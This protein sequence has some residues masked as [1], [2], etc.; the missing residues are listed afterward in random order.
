VRRLI[1]DFMEKEEAQVARRAPLR[2][3][4]APARRR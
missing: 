3:A 2:K 4:A 1:R